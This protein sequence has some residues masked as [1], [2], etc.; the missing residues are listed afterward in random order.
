MS[1]TKNMSSKTI[2]LA[3][4]IEQCVNPE[5]REAVR[6]PKYYKRKIASHMDNENQQR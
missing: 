1:K 5:A 3:Q 2:F 6:A 4:K